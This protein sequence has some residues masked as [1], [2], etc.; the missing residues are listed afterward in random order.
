VL[1]PVS[2]AMLRE[3]GSYDRVLESFSGSIHPFI[4]YATDDDE[5]IA[6]TNA[7]ADLY[8]YF[9]ATRHAEYL[10]DCIEDAI[11]RDLRAE[12]DFLKFRDA[13]VK[14]VM[15]IVDMPNQ[16]AALI[17]RLIH[18]SRGKL[19]PDKR[20]LF[21]EL[22]DEEIAKIESAIQSISDAITAERQIAPS[23]VE[24]GTAVEAQRE[25]PRVAVTSPDPEG[26]SDSQDSQEKKGPPEPRI[27]P[28]EP[29]PQA[30]VKSSALESTG[31]NQDTE[32]LP[33]PRVT[34]P[35]PPDAT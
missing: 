13:A 28:L 34:P 14:A 22:T 11:S 21:P 8:R 35:E 16:R 26:N 25:S 24:P 30:A 15:Q 27:T 12:L 7:T 3:M 6:V 1:F 33:E 4:E 32:S 9:D 18:Q 20:H 23:V 19:L 29:R 10:F 31:D 5:Q 2:A 17:V